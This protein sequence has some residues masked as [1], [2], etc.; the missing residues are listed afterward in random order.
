MEMENELLNIDELCAYLKIHKGTGYIW[1]WSGKIP[2]IK[3]GRRLL[4]RKRD[5][6]RWL[7]ANS[8]PAKNEGEAW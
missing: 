1:A 5:I 8:K 3:A 6:D 7:D 2:K 4:F